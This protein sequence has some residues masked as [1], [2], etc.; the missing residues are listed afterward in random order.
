MSE[1]LSLNRISYTDPSEALSPPQPRNGMGQAGLI[2]SACGILLFWVP[3]VYPNATL[4]GIVLSA[5]GLSRAR[6]GAATNGKTAMAG[7]AIGVLSL[8]VPGLILLGVA[9]LILRGQQ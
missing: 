9:T 5:I 4:I 1:G 6:A 7:L 3:M 2:L 8:V